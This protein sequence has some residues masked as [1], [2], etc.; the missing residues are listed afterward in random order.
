MRKFDDGDTFFKRLS[1]EERALLNDA[2]SLLGDPIKLFLKIRG[3]KK[4]Q[5]SRALEETEITKI[6]SRTE[7]SESAEPKGKAS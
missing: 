3:M 6:G 5:A 1:V 7:N 2:P 4:M